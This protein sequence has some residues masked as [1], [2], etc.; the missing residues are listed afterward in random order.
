VEFLIRDVTGEKHRSLPTGWDRGLT[1]ED[2]QKLGLDFGSEHERWDVDQISEYLIGEIT[3]HPRAT[4]HC[5]PAR[6]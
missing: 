3:R 2:K 1:E 5:I 6:R 4:G